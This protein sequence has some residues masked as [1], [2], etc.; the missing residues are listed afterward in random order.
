MNSEKKCPKCGSENYWSVDYKDE[1]YEIC[2]DCKNSRKYSKQMFLASFECEY[3][4]NDSGELFDHDDHISV[5][6]SICEQENIVLIKNNVRFDN[7]NKVG[8]IIDNK[9][10]QSTYIPKCPMC[11]SPNIRKLTAA[12]RITHGLAFGLFSKTA[13]SQWVCD[14]CGNKW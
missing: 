14:N 12:K 4:C 13:R 1:F 3:C 10:K 11:Q 9:P 7:R 5:V 6:C 2:S 8:I